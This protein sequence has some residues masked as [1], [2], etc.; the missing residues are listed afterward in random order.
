MTRSNSEQALVDFILRTINTKTS[1]EIIDIHDKMEL[2]LQELIGGGLNATQLNDLPE[3][4]IQNC[5][6]KEGL[7]KDTLDAAGLD[8]GILNRIFGSSDSQPSDQTW[9]DIFRKKQDLGDETLNKKQDEEIDFTNVNSVGRETLLTSIAN[10]KA[11]IADIQYGLNKGIIEAADM[12]NLGFSYDFIERLQSYV[13]QE[14]TFP[15]FEDLPPLRQNATDIYFLGMPGS[16]KSTM[17]A[18]LF[19]YCNEIGVMRNIVD[20]Q[21]GNKYRNQLVR[22][23]AQGY[24]PQSTDTK[25]INFIPVDMKHE[26]EKNCQQLNFL[27]MAGEKFKN[28]AEAGMSEFSSYQKYL[29]NK[30]PKC[31]IFVIDFIENNRVGILEQDQNLQQVLSLLEAYG[32]LEKTEA[33]YLVVTKADLFPSP[34]KQEYAD[35][36]V[37]TKYKNFLNAC[38]DAKDAYNFVLKSFPYSIGTTKFDYIL[39]DCEPTT[40]SNLVEFPKLL[41]EQLEH[42]MAYKRPGGLTGWFGR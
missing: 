7:D 21:F 39:E 15:E 13:T 40:N 28:V 3:N 17:L 35:N 5:V 34:N 30:N 22:G 23:M 6:N 32:I 42:D 24:L 18:A 26:D 9:E 14:V 8:N 12:A 31:L 38:K 1:N 4:F 37:R 2:T 25:F 10:N 33:V 11:L 41:L 36:Y 16:G 27:D 20:N 19:S 29:E